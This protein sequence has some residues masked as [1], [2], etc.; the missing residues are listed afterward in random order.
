MVADPP[1]S[2]R[3]C[4]QSSAETVDY[5]QSQRRTQ[6]S[7]SDDVEEEFNH[8]DENNNEL[9]TSSKRLLYERWLSKYPREFRARID[10]TKSEKPAQL[11]FGLLL[12][13]ILFFLGGS[14][15]ININ[16]ASVGARSAYAFVWLSLTVYCFLQTRD[17]L[18]VRPHPGVWRVVHGAALTHFVI[19]VILAALEPSLGR[20]FLALLLPDIA[21]SI[22]LRHVDPFEGTCDLDCRFS[23]RTL[24][25]QLGKL[26]FPCHLF[27]WLG[28]MVIYRSWVFCQVY[29]IAFELC[30]LSFQWLIPEFKEC[31]WD[32]IVLD[33]LIANMLGMC[34]GVYLLRWL[35]S[36]PYDWA[37]TRPRYVKLAVTFL[38]FTWSDYHWSFFSSVGGLLDAMWLLMTSLLV[39]L[40]SFFIMASLGIPAS[41]YFQLARL[42]MILLLAAPAVA[43]YHN[44]VQDRGNDNRR[45]GHNSWLILMTAIIE[46]IV[47]AK[48]GRDRFDRVTPSYDILAAWFVSIALFG[49]WCVCH[50]HI[51]ASE[52]KCDD[53]QSSTIVRAVGKLPVFVCS[54]PLCY[55]FRY[56]GYHPHGQ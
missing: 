49:L 30:E 51:S 34:L 36:Y 24:F 28:K 55:L 54:L 26:W 53:H 40:N 52:K 10:Y 45:L 17:G 11:T 5:T 27:G 9:S 20:Q 29:S 14:S 4:K 22:T 23:F 41:H 7:K 33:A 2:Q 39:E 46:V 48:Y 35:R 8:R 31:W 1:Q 37:G 38:P 15:K 6:S 16:D 42:I 18:M 25:V 12:L 3:R 32:S 19:M 47:C 56:Y 50:F 13:G 21:D 43:E 44:Y